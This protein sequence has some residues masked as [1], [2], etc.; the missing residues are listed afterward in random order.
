MFKRLTVGLGDRSYPIWVGDGILE[1]LGE[2]LHAVDFPRQVAV[3]TNPVVSALYG[4]PVMTALAGSGFSPSLITVPD[5]EEHKNLRTLEQI[6]DAL[7]GGGFDRYCGLIA[8]GG[9]VIGDIT[10]F[11][12]ATFLRG[13]P[14]A[15]VPTT[16]LAQVDSSVGGKTA[17]NHPL[18]KNLIG[19]F[20]QPRHVHID[21][22]TLATLPEREFAAG[23]AEVI[24]YGIIRDAE[25]FFWLGAQCAR[26]RQRNREALVTAVMKSC[27]IKADIV[28]LDEKES[29][30]RAILNYGHTF[31]HAV[32]TLAGYG[33]IRHGEAVAIGMSVAARVSREFGF[34]SPEQVSVIDALLQAF[35]LPVTPPPFH[36]D[37]YL[38]A[39]GRDKKVKAGVLRYVFNRGIG[40]CLVDDIPDPD[41]LFAKI[42]Q[43]SSPDGQVEP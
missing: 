15:Q 5:G 9:G 38:Q 19:A 26:L 25:F 41:R 42:L 13:V 4:Q 12:A 18:G 3:V 2:A 37:D 22:A 39:M 16:L 40:D 34:C 24:K 21:V 31:G 32:E 10:G 27:Q 30:L 8:L 43:N 33:E 36:L 17:V 14:F 29:S 28:E 23:M 20:Y 6:Y 7:I 35:A 1:R 11:A